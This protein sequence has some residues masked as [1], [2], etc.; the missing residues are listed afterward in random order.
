MPCS[1]VTRRLRSWLLWLLFCSLQN[2]SGLNRHAKQEQ[3]LLDP[4]NR[5]VMS[6][7][8][9]TKYLKPSYVLM[10]QVRADLSEC[11]CTS[12]MMPSHVIVRSLSPAGGIAS[13][14]CLLAL[15]EGDTQRSKTITTHGTLCRSL[16]SSGRNLLCT[17]GAL[18]AGGILC[19]SAW[20]S[21]ALPLM[22]LWV[23]TAPLC[24]TL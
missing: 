17:Q 12:V 21:W 24:P 3:V 18:R 15:H 16:T 20:S 22:L 5:L 9:I 1:A 19:M 23:V 4:K 6:Y 2:M 10:E 14:L 7:V 8:H 13:C 11:N